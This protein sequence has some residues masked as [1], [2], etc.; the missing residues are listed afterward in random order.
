FPRLS[1]DGLTLMLVVGRSPGAG[2]RLEATSRLT[3]D[4]D[5]DEPVDLGP[6]NRGVMSGLSLSGDETAVYFSTSRTLG[7]NARELWMSRRVKKPPQAVAPESAKSGFSQPT[8][9]PVEQANSIRMKGPLLPSGEYTFVG[10]LAAA[11]SDAGAIIK[12]NGSG[13]TATNWELNRHSK[14]YAFAPLYNSKL[15]SF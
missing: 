10:W 4:A 8:A 13:D 9:L 7:V 11:G 15:D 5:F 3:V 14:G 1:Q 12:V 6:V 2:L